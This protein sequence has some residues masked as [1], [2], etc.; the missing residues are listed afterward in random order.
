MPL[1]C[2]LTVYRHYNVIVEEMNEFIHIDDQLF[3]WGTKDKSLKL[4]EQYRFLSFKQV[5]K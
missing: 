3:I 5:L 1:Y 2:K 4:V